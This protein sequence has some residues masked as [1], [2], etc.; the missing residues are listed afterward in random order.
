[1]GRQLVACDTGQSED[2]QKTNKIRGEQAKPSQTT[3]DKAPRHQ[4]EH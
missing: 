2:L 1:M 4:E 3:E